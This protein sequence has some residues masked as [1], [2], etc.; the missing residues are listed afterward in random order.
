[1]ES[2]VWKS[3]L[4]VFVFAENVNIE[5]VFVFVFNMDVFESDFQHYLYLTLS[6]IIRHISDIGHIHKE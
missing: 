2:D 4:S 6:D 1:M 3:K 5:Y